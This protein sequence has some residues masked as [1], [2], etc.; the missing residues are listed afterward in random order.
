MNKDI[1]DLLKK[2]YPNSSVVEQIK[3]AKLINNN[4]IYIEVN[5]DGIIKSNIYEIVDDNLYLYKRSEVLSKSDVFKFKSIFRE[6]KINEIV[7][8]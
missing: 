2:H 6:L 5:N 3:S 8:D 1:L 7:E 4:L